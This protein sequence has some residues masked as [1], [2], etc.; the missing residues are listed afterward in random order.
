MISP[1]RRTATAAALTA[2]AL[3]A[4]LVAAAP[5]LAATTTL[6][7]G[8]T[9]C[10]DAGSG[11]Q[12]Q[13]YCTISA[14]AAS[15]T[16]GQT[17]LVAPGSYSEQVTV[18]NSGTAGNPIVFQSATRGAAI[19][20]GGTDG[21][22]MSG[23]NYVTID[24][25]AVTATTGTG[26]MLSGGS[27]LTVANT[28][29]TYAGHP[30]SGQN[31]PGIDIANT[32]DSLLTGN[33]SDHNSFYGFHVTGTSTR[34][35][36][37]GN[38]A[39]FNA[40]GWQRN[41]NGIDITAPGDTAI[42][43]VLH[44]NEDSGLQFYPGGDNGTAVD[45]V[46]YNNGDHGIDDLNVTGGVLTG[47]TVYDNCTDGINIEGTS[48]NYTVQ[49]NVSVNNA[50]NT[51]C[52]HGP[53]GKDGSGRAGDI[54]LY[55]SAATGSSADY[56]LVSLTGGTGKL[57]QWGATGYTSLAAFQSATGQGAHDLQADPKF[58][59]ASSRDFHLTAGSPAIDS[60]N[61][62]AP[63]QPATDAAGNARFDDPNT[64]NTGAGT[65]TYDDRGAYEFQSGAPVGN[66]PTAALTI[67]AA[68]A[69]LSVNADASAST[70]GTTAI[71]T[72]SFDYG[73]STSSGAQTS[74][75]ATHTYATAGTYIATVTVTDIDGLSATK[76]APIAVTAPAT[77]I[78]HVG[79]RPIASAAATATG[80][81]LT[82]PITT[83][84]HTGDALLLSAML[85]S[86]T[87]GT[88][89]AVDTKGNTYHYSAAS[90]VFDA[91]KH[92]TLILAAYNT[93]ALT[94]ADHITL[95]FPSASKYNVEVD[96]FSGI[97]NLDQQTT[98]SGAS[99]GT[100]FATPAVTT[101][102]SSEL[103]FTAV[104][105]NSGTA[106]TFGTGWHALAPVANSSY[107]LNCAWQ[108]VTTTGSYTS[109]GTTT[110]QW[111]AALDTFH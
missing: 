73:D 90:D 46:I 43:N 23:R 94:T 69:A 40:E 19:V 100:T 10:S 32:T 39:S 86:T 31:A 83:A 55:D 34:V 15:A 6:Y 92:R 89:T 9:S 64:P 59:N 17:V 102:T 88:F 25:F 5:A 54:G 79:T 95:T 27:N 41:A 16:A 77:T 109:S 2:A 97:S 96:E 84:S 49:N 33:T 42:G 65:R 26:I 28:T 74:A 70:A 52:A 68:H 30:V 22:L 35:V 105:T 18:P 81:G 85:T 80:T 53:V 14:A 12:A 62:A 57:Y 4:A 67:A 7:V 20:T 13:P 87:P 36:L 103:L 56:N 75:T 98:A 76:T 47:N 60:A 1:T 48:G 106:A 71:K 11:T 37:S 111:G 101:T 72:Y 8:G 66:P 38:E 82:I 3:A 78:S 58:A 99:G 93:T 21:F 110:S 51:A 91:S 108:I 107:R 24:G 44:D 63:A 50:T 29:V 61:S 45:N 104:G